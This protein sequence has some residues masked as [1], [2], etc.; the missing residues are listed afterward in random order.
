MLL[1][2]TRVT[3]GK[4]CSYVLREP[5]N[6]T[7]INKTMTLKEEMR[8]RW[9]DPYCIF[10]VN[11]SNVSCQPAKQGREKRQRGR[12]DLW[13]DLFIQCDP[14]DLKN[15]SWMVPEINGY[16]Y[17]W[18]LIAETGLS[19]A[20][21]WAQWVLVLP[22]IQESEMCTDSLPC[23]PLPLPTLLSFQV[24]QAQLRLSVP[25]E[26]CSFTMAV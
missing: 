24:M 15:L 22:A 18:T 12:G 1:N 25:P 26:V 23:A 2:K 6:V 7:L 16:T 21:S 4:S 5:W 11:T 17:F 20:T 14:L 13:K 3:S 8:P 9:L 19:S 10:S